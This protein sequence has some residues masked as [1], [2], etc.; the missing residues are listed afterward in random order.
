MPKKKL[1]EKELTFE[2]LVADSK[3]IKFQ[4][5]ENA[6]Q[7]SDNVAKL[8]TKKFKITKGTKVLVKLD[9]NNVV[10]FIQKTKDA[11]KAEP[12]NNDNY[13]EYTIHG[14]PENKKVI[15]FKEVMDKW[16]DVASELQTRDLQAEG[17]VAR[18]KVKVKIEKIDG[19]DIITDIKI[20]NS[21]VTEASANDVEVA[22]DEISTGNSSVITSYDNKYDIG[23]LKNRIQY[24]ES[25]QRE[26]IEKQ[27]ALNR[28]GD[29]VCK[30]IEVKSPL[31]DSIDKIKNVLKELTNVTKEIV[32]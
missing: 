22:T 29:I 28:A 1:I 32:K 3:V 27:T 17:I 6:Y 10:Q 31:V 11:P 13:K 7:V 14:I 5:N 20:S 30:L 9:D 4:E 23:R 8:D 18:A 2:Y 16:Y 24:L 15:K 25:V 26:S 12:S 19:T 21:E